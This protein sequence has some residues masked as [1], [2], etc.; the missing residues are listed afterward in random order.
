[1]S[2]SEVCLEDRKGTVWSTQRTIYHS[3]LF[4]SVGLSEKLM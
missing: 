4:V 3:P 1:M 2:T